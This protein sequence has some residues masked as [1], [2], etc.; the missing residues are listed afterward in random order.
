MR[1]LQ[2]PDS[3]RQRHGREENLLPFAPINSTVEAPLQGDTPDA[4]SPSSARNLFTARSETTM[5]IEDFRQALIEYPNHD[6]LVLQ[7]NDQTGKLSLV[8]KEVSTVFFRSAQETLENKAALEELRKWALASMAPH[9]PSSLNCS[10]ILAHSL[11][12][13]EPL[14]SETLRRVLFETTGTI[15]GEE[16]SYEQQ[17]SLADPTR[18]AIEDLPEDRIPPHEAAKALEAHLKTAFSTAA[19]VHNQLS[20]FRLT[21]EDETN[22]YK[23]EALHPNEK[24][25]LLKKD[26]TP[27]PGIR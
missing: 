16:G 25:P 24:I 12:S 8:G 27:T 6:R 9:A 7:K 10:F 26:K 4:S 3:D 19:E 11:S 22:R 23:N 2:Q 18:N 17:A 5:T 15:H 21:S 13:G 14:S 20:S 1:H